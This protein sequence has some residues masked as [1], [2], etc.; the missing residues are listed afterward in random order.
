M[1]QEEDGAAHDATEG[2]GDDAVHDVV[3]DRT[4][5][6]VNEQNREV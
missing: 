4:N 6:A 2:H 5:A 1:P 3:E